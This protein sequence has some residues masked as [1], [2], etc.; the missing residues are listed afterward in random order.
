MRAAEALAA[1]ERARREHDQ[2]GGC[3]FFRGALI[4]LLRAEALDALGDHAKAR[5]AIATAQ[6]RLLAIATR[7][8]DAAYRRSFL[9]GVPE[10]RRTLDLARA[11]LTEGGPE[12]VVSAGTE[13]PED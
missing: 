11:W 12:E 2:V 5:E 9:E 7:I 3:A 10:N 13:H 4:R 8:D 1:A 6:Q